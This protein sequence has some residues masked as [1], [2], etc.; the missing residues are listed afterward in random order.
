MVKAVVGV[1]EIRDEVGVGEDRKEVVKVGIGG[2]NVVEEGEAATISET[3][4]IDLDRTIKMAA[5]I[6]QDHD[7]NMN[8]D[9]LL[10]YIGDEGWK[11][12]PQRGFGNS[13]VADVDTNIS[14]EQ[15]SNITPA[16]QKGALNL[17]H[18]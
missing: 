7:V 13:T 18:I 11:S 6:N 1:H 16:L 10:E 5:T 9:S 3:E 15:G 12:L 14:V 4:L 2:S 17:L 8:D